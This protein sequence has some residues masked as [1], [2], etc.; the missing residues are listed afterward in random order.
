MFCILVLGGFGACVLVGLCKLQCLFLILL[1]CGLI[2]DSFA[3]RWLCWLAFGLDLNCV[4]GTWV[5][6]LLKCTLW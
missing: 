4:A 1:Y 5:V 2:G 6:D 3:S